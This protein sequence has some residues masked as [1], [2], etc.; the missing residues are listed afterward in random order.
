MD[1][2][3]AR[4]SEAVTTHRHQ[5]LAKIRKD[6]GMSQVQLAA[7]SSVGLSS[8]QRLEQGDPA[9]GL[10]VAVKVASVL[11]V[12]AS[13]FYDGDDLPAHLRDGG[14]GAPEWAVRQHDEIMEALRAVIRKIESRTK[15]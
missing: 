4:Q 6:R 9:V 14:S 2:E 8:I 5:L 3:T 15:P 13:V 12:D 1:D 10:G 7:A 11:G